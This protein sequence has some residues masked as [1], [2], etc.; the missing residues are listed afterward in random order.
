MTFP[1]SPILEIDGIPYF[2]RLCDKIRLHAAGELP[3]DYHA[4]LGKG[5]DL[6]TCRFLG[7]EY[8][9]LVEVVR[10]GASDEEALKWACDHG[11]QRPDYEVDWWR[12]A[13]TSLGFRDSLAP[14]LTKRK[15]ESGLGDRGDILTFFD[16][17]EADEGRI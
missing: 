15:Q 7:I 13:M 12:H 16:F 6:S 8:D 5:F 1:C 17:I 10:S 3:E 2:R 9:Q 11:V 4:N 14:I